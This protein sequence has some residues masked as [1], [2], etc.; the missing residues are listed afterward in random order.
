MERITVIKALNAGVLIIKRFLFLFLFLFITMATAMAQKTIYGVVTDEADEPL[1]GVSIYIKGTKTGTMTN[2]EGKFQMR[3]SSEG[4]I[5]NFSYI[6]MDSYQVSVKGRNEFNVKLHESSSALSEVTVVSTGYQ[7]LSRERS[8]G[9]FGFVDSTKLSSQNFENLEAALEGKVAG[10]R[11]N[12]VSDGTSHEPI[13]RGV[14]TLSSNVGTQALIVIDNM[15]TDMALSDINPYIVESI[16]VLKDAAAAS[17]YGAR[18]ANGVIVITTKEARREGVHVSVNADWF[19]TAKQ[20]FDALHLQSASQY[21]DNQTALY[22]SY[23][24]EA[25]S[26]DAY[27]DNLASSY[28]SPLY[29]LYRDQND[30]KVSQSDVDAQLS[31]WRKNDYYKEY[32]DVMW[33]TAITQRYNVSISQ[34]AGKS[35]HSLNF[36]YSNS[37]GQDKSDFGTNAFN[38]YYHSNYKVNKWLAVNAGIDASLSDAKSGTSYGYAGQERYLRLR[39]DNGNNI[40]YANAHAGGYVGSGVNLNAIESVAHPELYMPFTFS[41]L[42]Q[43]NESVVKGKGTSLRPFVNVEVGFLKFFHYRLSYQYEWHQNK[44]QRYDEK[45]SYAMRMTHNAMITSD[46]KSLLPEGGR[47]YQMESSG[48]G[49][50]LRNQ[51][52]FDRSL[53]NHSVSAIMGLEFRQSHT[54]R[55]LEDVRYGYNPQT[56]TSARMDWESLFEDGWESELYGRNLSLSGTPV[57]QFITKHRYASFYANAGYTFMQKYN[58]T[59]SLRFDEAD[60]FGLDTNQQKHPLWSIGAGW[61][62]SEEAFMKKIPWL[63]Y[64]R[65]RATYGINGNVDQAST[66][67]FVAT[68]KTQRN[69]VA[70]TYLEYGDDDLPNP[71][72]RWEKTATTNLGADFRLFNNILSGSIE[73]YNRHASDLLVRRYLDPTLGAES[74][75]VNNGEMRNRGIELSLSANIV[76]ARDWSVSANL[77]YA[78]NTNKILDVDV[79]A[80]TT[81][82]SFILSPQNFFIEGTS[83]NTLW[84]YR[85]DRIENG[86]PVVVDENG[87]DMI[88]FDAAGD[89][90]SIKYSASLKGTAA[91]KNCGT[92]T[93]KYHGGIGLDVRW[94]E[95]ELNAQFIYSGGNKLR[96]PTASLQRGGDDTYES[97]TS[98][99]GTHGV[100]LYKDMSG[101]ARQYASTFDE[102]WQYSD[103]QVKSAAFVKLR[104]ISLSCRMPSLWCHRIGLNS[105]RLRLQVNN[106]LA[107]SAAGNDIDPETFGLNGGS[108]SMKTPKTFSIGLSASF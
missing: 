62:V 89:V 95:L 31:Q 14:G 73:Y 78:H 52:N 29:Q 11:V 44:T 16:T 46:G 100:R 43:L 51:L 28:Y 21:I 6:G 41:V 8:T 75:V 45:D 92:I 19:L 86:Y 99:D 58:V 57:R 33:R 4:D 18:A 61:L 53:A 80:A 35:N 83:Y 49:Y 106:I 96:M 88:T 3:V 105:V 25:G 50:T 54:P 101:A 39:D 76:R 32:R 91:L 103:A 64:L 102:W 7:K 77:T 108:R 104:N 47:Y 60:L 20:R 70:A 37:K 59:G 74:R 72:L 85:L 17:I 98:W 69:P 81:A 38:I 10:L 24:E 27:F 87:D 22:R 1:M 2:E 93:P 48:N 36:G 13:I 84:A 34:Q 42:D 30:G 26:A 63:N 5:L 15:P 107:W 82:S 90:A 23:I 68:Y 94:K 65:L 55:I 79:D 66:T 9:S 40:I 71:R 12:T 67:Y 56:L 97:L